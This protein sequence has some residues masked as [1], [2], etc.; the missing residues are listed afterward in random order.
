MEIM[1]VTLICNTVP[2]DKVSGSGDNERICSV[3]NLYPL[4]M[5]FEPLHEI[6]NNLAF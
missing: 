2:N 3:L 4:V 5:T 1:V 6:S